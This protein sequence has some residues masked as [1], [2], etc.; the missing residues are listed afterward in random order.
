MSYE[1]ELALRVAAL[2]LL[3]GLAVIAIVRD[4]AARVRVR[5]DELSAERAVGWDR[6][7]P[8]DRARV[9]DWTYGR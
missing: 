8:E 3:G 6:L 4:A 1:V 5:D 2:P 7:S 9:V